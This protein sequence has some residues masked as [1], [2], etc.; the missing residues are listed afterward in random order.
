MPAPEQ[1]SFSGIQSL[2][3][4][5]LLYQSHAPRAQHYPDERTDRSLR[6]D[7]YLEVLVLM[8]IS[9]SS[10]RRAAR[11]C[12]RCTPCNTGPKSGV[13]MW[14]ILSRS[15]GENREFGGGVSAAAASYKDDRA[16]TCFR[17]TRPDFV[18]LVTG[19]A[20]MAVSGG[21]SLSMSGGVLM[22]LAPKVA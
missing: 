13:Q 17:N 2:Q 16:G 15:N 18:L 10:C 20:R 3:V 6:H 22:T 11:C 19:C 9:P 5:D 1:I 12:Y 8:E 4:S 7:L 14:K 21:A